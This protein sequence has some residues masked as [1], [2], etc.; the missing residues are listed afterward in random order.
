MMNQLDTLEDRINDLEEKAYLKDDLGMTYKN[1]KYTFKVWSPHAQSVY[2][3]IYKSILYTFCY[4]LYT[5]YIHFI[6]CPV[7]ANV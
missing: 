1:G 2:L 5:F 6:V 4:C 3:N 7:A